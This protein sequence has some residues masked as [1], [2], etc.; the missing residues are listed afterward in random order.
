M[1]TVFGLTAMA[2]YLWHAREL[3]CWAWR[4]ESMSLANA[5]ATAVAEQG[6]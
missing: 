6:G 2:T 5:C 4:D 1:V 3:L